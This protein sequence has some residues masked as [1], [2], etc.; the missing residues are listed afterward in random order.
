MPLQHLL[1]QVLKVFDAN[2]INAQCENID[3]TP[4]CAQHN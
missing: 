3:W 4:S 2:E 1:L